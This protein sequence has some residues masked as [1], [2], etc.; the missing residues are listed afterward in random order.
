MHYFIGLLDTYC[1]IL[2]G[3]LT[4]KKNVLLYILGKFDDISYL[5]EKMTELHETFN[6]VYSNSIYLLNLNN[7]LY[8]KL[9]FWF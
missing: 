2:S 5:S 6:Q 3:N 8:I 7:I 9:F 1:K 4:L